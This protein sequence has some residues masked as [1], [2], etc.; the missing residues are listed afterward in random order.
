MYPRPCSLLMAHISP[1]LHP[2]QLIKLYFIHFMPFD[3]AVLSSSLRY[4]N[5]QPNYISLCT[6]NLEG[7]LQHCLANRLPSPW[8]ARPYRK[9]T[10]RKYCSLFHNAKVPGGPG[11][12]H[13]RCF[14]ISLRHTTLGRIPLDNW[15][16]SRRNLYLTTHYTHKTQ[17]FM[18]SGGN[19]IGNA[20]KRAAA[21]AHLRPC[22]H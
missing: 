14:T 16:A 6:N 9:E 4:F 15:S 12:P 20:S 11:P 2:V 1:L 18:P 13:F 19:R 8:M 21:D 22:S 17:T 7:I 5:I 10:S 3:V